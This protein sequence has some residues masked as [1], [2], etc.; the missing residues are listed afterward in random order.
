MKTIKEASTCQGTVPWHIF[1]FF[2]IVFL[3][4]AKGLSPGR[5]FL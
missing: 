4:P 5:L 3:P 1:K 2:I